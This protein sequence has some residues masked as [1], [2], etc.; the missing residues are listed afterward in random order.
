VS[1]PRQRKVTIAV[2][3]LLAGSLCLLYV[4]NFIQ[5]DDTSGAGS[6]KWVMWLGYAA[7][8]AA[9]ASVIVAAFEPNASRLHGFALLGVCLLIGFLRFTVDGFRFVWARDEGELMILLVAV[10]L[11][12]LIMTTARSST[13]TS[14]RS[15]VGGWTRTV[16]Y[17]CGVVVAMFVAFNAGVDYFDRTVCSAPGVDGDCGAGIFGGLTWASITLLVGLAAVVVSEVAIRWRRARVRTV[18]GAH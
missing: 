17:Q 1:S 18:G 14:P 2:T 10:S 12:G 4:G 8:Y 5:F 13:R 11:L 9:V 15:G 7:G 6:V 16:A 3:A